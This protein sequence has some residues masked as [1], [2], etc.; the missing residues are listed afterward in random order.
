MSL[1]VLIPGTLPSSSLLSRIPFFYS[2][3]TILSFQS[4]NLH[5]ICIKLYCL[6][7]HLFPFSLGFLDIN[8][9]L[10]Q[11]SYQGQAEIE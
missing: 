4:R 10:R 2:N 7:T 3:I 9:P 6:F 1:L 8:F 11:E 5:S